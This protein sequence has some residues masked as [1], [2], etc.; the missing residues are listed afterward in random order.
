MV[1]RLQ[2]Q[3]TDMH[4]HHAQEIS[5]LWQKNAQLQSLNLSWQPKDETPVGAKEE[6]MTY[7][8]PWVT[9]I[10]VKQDT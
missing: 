4:R 5:T 2:A 10:S 7:E 1:R 3:V 8:I 6:P 9:N